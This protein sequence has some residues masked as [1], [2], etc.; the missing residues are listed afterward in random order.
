MSSDFRNIC[1]GVK[2]W[3][4]RLKGKGTDKDHCDFMVRKFHTPVTNIQDIGDRI[5]Q[6]GSILDQKRNELRNYFPSSTSAY[7][8]TVPYT[9]TSLK[10][11]GG[12]KPVNKS[13]NTKFPKQNIT[14]TT[15][16]K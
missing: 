9:D 14:T 8:G 4:R 16:N 13:G 5:L 15:P 7:A 11:T 10:S 6:W 3:T 2:R 1:N 12:N